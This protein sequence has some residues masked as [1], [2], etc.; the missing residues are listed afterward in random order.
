MVYQVQVQIQQYYINPVGA[1]LVVAVLGTMLGCLGY[2]LSM[3]K[4]R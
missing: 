4:A 1:F 3:R 2:I